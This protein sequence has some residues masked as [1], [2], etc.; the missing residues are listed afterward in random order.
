MANMVDL[1][2][3][4]DPTQV[5]TQFGSLSYRSKHLANILEKAD[6]VQFFLVSYNPR[7]LWVLATV[8]PDKETIYYMDSL[9]N[10]MVDEDLRNI[11]N[12]A[13]KIY[14]SHVGK[15]SPLAFEKKVK[16]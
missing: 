14:N 11:V 3:L 10:R 13:I 4:V 9:P 12:I 2:S 8:R 7:D 1:V 16:N 15:Q 5:S 6:G